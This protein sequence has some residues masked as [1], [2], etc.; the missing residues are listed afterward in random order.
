MVVIVAAGNACAALV[1]S[2]TSLDMLV[3]VEVIIGVDVP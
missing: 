1:G 3:F 2:A